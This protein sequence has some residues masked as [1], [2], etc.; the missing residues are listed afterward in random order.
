MFSKYDEEA[1]K[2][3][4]NMQKEMVELRHPYIGSE[5]L[6]LSLLKYGDKG[7]ISKFSDVDVTYDSFKNELINVVGVGKSKNEFF[8]YTPLLRN[9]LESASMNSTDKGKKFVDSDDL[10]VSLFEEGEGVAIRILI[11][12]GV[13]VDELYDNFS[14]DNKSKKVKLLVEDFGVNLNEKVKNGEIDP[15]IGRDKEISRLVEIL[16]RRTK[17]NALLI[18][19]AGVGKTAIVEELARNLEGYNVPFKLANKRIISV[20]MAS[21]VAGTKY[22]GEFEERLEKIISELEDN[23]E[24]I[25]FIDEIHTLVGA[26][27]AEGAIDAGNILKPALARGKIKV[28]G[29]TTVSEY[30][31][32]IE[33]DKALSRRFQT[34]LIEE[35]SV[36]ATLD[37]LKKLRPIYEEFHGVKISDDILLEIVTL[38][39]K[40]IY[41]RRMPDKAIDV[42]DEVCSRVSV[43]SF[44][45]SSL[46]DIN[47]KLCEIKSL[48]NKSIIN[49]KFN[50]AFLYKKTEMIL[51]DKKNRIE[52]KNVNKD[53]FKI[54]VSDVFKIVEE[55]TNIPLYRNSYKVFE[56][57]KKSLSCSVLGQDN[58]ISS[59][60]DSFKKRCYLSS[61]GKRPMSFLFVGPTGVGKTLLAKSYGKCLYGDS[62]IRVDMS[63]YREGH[64]ISK[65]IGSPPGYVGYSDNKSVFEMVKDR[66][67][68]LIILDE[69]EKGSREVLNLF[70][71][72][73]DEGVCKNSK[74]EVIN[75]ANTTII[76]TSNLGCNKSNIG[77]NDTISS[78]DIND[79]FGI[80]FVNRIANIIY[81]NKISS[82]IC[83]I[84][85][86]NKLNLVRKFYKE[87]GINCSFS[88]NVISEIRELCEYEKFG[89]RKIDMVIEQRLES[90]LIDKMIN[91]INKVRLDTI[92]DL[93]V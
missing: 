12:M 27:G 25:L 11:G 37:I 62:I 88:N 29:A 34:V 73:L 87:K 48:K 70:L 80:E 89:A 54:K 31:E 61:D 35:P 85:I 53:K 39:D 15:V 75:F 18:G 2:I 43:A 24:I 14:Y 56:N 79:F 38:S 66:P 52:L 72:I 21:L 32:F 55:M 92:R 4:L 36:S 71:Q 8:L 20:S 91:G 7:I 50:E 86:K 9:I 16:S 84:L 90:I 63:E 68:S 3:L 46:G 28:I 74:G 44:S 5:H 93:V 26:G 82:E 83:D 57:L 45:D 59:I 58:A 67:Y 22:R 10:F 65:L 23:D 49:N 6:L 17:N 47:E 76:M 64:S 30:K 40:Y 42:M 51:E 77:F 69:V 1:K 19:E 13:D 41:D 33:T 81:F 78:L 60:L